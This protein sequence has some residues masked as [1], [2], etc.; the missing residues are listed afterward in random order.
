MAKMI[1]AEL[2]LEAIDGVPER[3]PH[4]AGIG[5]HGIERPP[6]CDDCVGAG[7]YVPERGEMRTGRGKE[8][9]FTSFYR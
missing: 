4:H 7:S 6:V 3:R 5:D 9:S 2:R 8:Q 1:G